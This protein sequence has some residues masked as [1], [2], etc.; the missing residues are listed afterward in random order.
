MIASY[1]EP[2]IDSVPFCI[3]CWMK[4]SGKIVFMDRREMDVARS[5]DSMA[6]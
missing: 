4:K 1:M 6:V 2:F 5:V 3:K